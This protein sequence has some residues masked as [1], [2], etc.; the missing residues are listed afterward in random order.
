M[1][2]LTRMIAVGIV[3]AT[4]M[5]HSLFLGSALATQDRIS[6]KPLASEDDL[7]SLSDKDLQ[8]PPK[9]LAKRAVGK[10]VAS[11]K[12]AF[13]AP[14]PSTYA[15]TAKRHCDRENNPLGFVSAHVYHGI[16]DIVA[17]LL[18]FAVVINSLYVFFLSLPT[19][20]TANP[21]PAS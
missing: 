6:F 15:T 14:P 19:T 11:V 17:S 7:N 3:G 13:T 20:C 16:V 4:V 10:V 5:P 18:G 9:S 12:A 21:D 1:I 2:A 8:D